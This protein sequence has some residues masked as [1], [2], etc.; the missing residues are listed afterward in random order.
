MNNVLDCV[1]GIDF[2]RQLAM[3]IDGRTPSTRYLGSDTLTGKVWSGGD[4]PTLLEPTVSWVD[5][6]VAKFLVTLTEAQTATLDPGTYRLQVEAFR[7]S[8]GQSDILFNGSLTVTGTSGAAEAL[9]ASYCS[10]RDLLMV[11]PW[12][13]T[14]QALGQDQAT[15]A[16]QR[17]EARY[18]LDDLVLAAAPVYGYGRSAHEE[19]ILYWDGSGGLGPNTLVRDLLAADRLIVTRKV[20]KI[21][22]L[23]AGY[24]ILRSQVTPGDNQY[25]KLAGQYYSEAMHEAT[26]TI[27][28]VARNATDTCPIPITLGTTSTRW[29]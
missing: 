9:A 1:R 24:L 13:E 29:A 12:I 14:Q 4:Q 15:F 16:E 10:Y 21:C 17:V 11:A 22:A 25:A 3:T 23:Y 19:A 5:A 8:N 6:T 18:W 28:E 7:A 27:V 20:R 26:N 2:R